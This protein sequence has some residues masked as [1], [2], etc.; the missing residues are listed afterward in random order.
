MDIVVQDRPGQ[1][2]PQIGGDFILTDHH[3]S[4]RSSLEFRG[5]Y[6]LVY[7]GYSFCPDICP[8]G[9]ENISG[10]LRALGRDLSDVAP[11]FITVDPDRD[12]AGNLKIYSGNFHPKLLMLTG[13]P[14]E[15]ATVLKSYK[16]YAAKV[17]PDGTMADYLMDH[18]TLI[19]FMDR[20]GHFLKSFPH[21]IAPEELARAII[22][23]LTDDKKRR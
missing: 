15:I 9:L 3:G 2:V 1:G 11:I 13:T 6:M 21:T 7:F 22:L 5:K 18:S 16:V 4:R 8:L 23:I 19:Y 17:K 14:Y 12:T 10:A 20:Q